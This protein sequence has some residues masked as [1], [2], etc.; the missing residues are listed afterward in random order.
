MQGS[1]TMKSAA[2]A[3]V[4]PVDDPAARALVKAAHSRMYKL[5]V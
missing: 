4:K 2:G 5:V 3:G 1:G